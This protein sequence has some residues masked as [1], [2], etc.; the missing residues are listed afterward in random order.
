MYQ[1]Y[2]SDITPQG[3]KVA[4]NAMRLKLWDDNV[5]AHRWLTHPDRECFDGCDEAAIPER[6]SLYMSNIER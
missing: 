4:R 6:L 3:L 5:F 1:P 2:T